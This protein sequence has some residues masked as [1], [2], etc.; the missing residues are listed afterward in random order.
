MW[1]GKQLAVRL[2]TRRSAV[3][4]GVNSKKSAEGKED[5]QRALWVL[6]I[7]LGGEFPLAEDSKAQC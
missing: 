1:M 4:D 3:L 2:T 6:R 7:Q 5:L